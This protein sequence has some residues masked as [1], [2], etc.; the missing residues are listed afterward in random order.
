MKSWPTFSS[1]VIS[2]V[3]EG[4]GDGDGGGGATTVEVGGE[5]REV[6][7]GVVEHPA[8]TRQTGAEQR[9]VEGHPDTVAATTPDQ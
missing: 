8:T 9:P 6:R 2:S 1:T 5:G 4:E 7:G 3:G